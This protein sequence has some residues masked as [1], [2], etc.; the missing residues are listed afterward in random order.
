MGFLLP[1]RLLKQSRKEHREFLRPLCL[2]LPNR[3]G[4][5]PCLPQKSFD[6]SVSGYI[7]L[8]LIHPKGDIGFRRIA[9][10]ASAVAMP[11]ASMNENRYLVL[12]QHNVW[13]ARKIFA[14][15]AKPESEPMEGGTDEKLRSSIAASDA[16]HIPAS[17]LW[18][19]PVGHLSASGSWKMLKTD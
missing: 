4:F 12:R 1:N 11:I 8:K 13:F 3:D 14:V 19:E 15:K 7:F 6:F 9:I 10:F 18:G 16:R 2:T 17:V 5:P